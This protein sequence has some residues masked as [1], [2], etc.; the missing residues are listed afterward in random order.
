M[1]QVVVNYEGRTF[2]VFRNEHNILDEDS[3]LDKFLVDDPFE[4]LEWVGVAYP[5][6][7]I[8]LRKEEKNGKKS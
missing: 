6:A 4:I 1:Y 2:Q 7:E 3:N 8:E 5:Q